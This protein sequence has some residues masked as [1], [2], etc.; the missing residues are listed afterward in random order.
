MCYWRDE[1][2]ARRFCWVCIVFSQK[3]SSPPQSQVGVNN[4]NGT[5]YVPSSRSM[6]LLMALL[7]LNTKLYNTPSDKHCYAVR[8]I[9]NALKVETRVTT[10]II[11]IY[12]DK[13]IRDP[14]ILNMDVLCYI[15]DYANAWL[16]IMRMFKHVK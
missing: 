16:D 7:L 11:K 4:C 15:N 9:S 10:I 12:S 3:T 1:D 6:Y 14:N 8:R 5:I 13:C 2:E